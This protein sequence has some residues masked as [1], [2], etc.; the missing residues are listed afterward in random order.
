MKRVGVTERDGVGEK[1]MWVPCE[2]RWMTWYLRGE[3]W[4]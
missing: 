1:G 2:D 4:P 3:K